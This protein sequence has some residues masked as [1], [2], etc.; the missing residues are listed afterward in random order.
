MRY[1]FVLSLLFIGCA[2]LE[3][4][5]AILFDCTCAV[6]CDGNSQTTT[7]PQ[8]SK[9]SEIQAAIDGAV[10]ECAAEMQAPPACGSYNCNCSCTA[11]EPETECAIE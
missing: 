4:E 8:C 7:G 11:Q 6:T 1:A 10:A 3:D 5:P 9:E 2:E